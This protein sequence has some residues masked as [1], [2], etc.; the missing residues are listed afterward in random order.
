MGEIND[1]DLAVKMT[2]DVATHVFLFGF[3]VSGLFFLLG[4][5]LGI[6]LQG[7][8]FYQHNLTWIVLTSLAGGVFYSF[9]GLTGALRDAIRTVV[10]R[11]S[12]DG[13]L[14]IRVK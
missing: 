12:E 6:T 4:T 7:W 5:I 14:T 8:L 3:V 11:S 1:Y 13:T 9:V 10:A 2:D